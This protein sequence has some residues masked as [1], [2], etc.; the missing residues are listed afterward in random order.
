MQDLSRLKDQCGG[1]TPAAPALKHAHAPSICVPAPYLHHMQVEAPDG[2]ASSA[3]RQGAVQGNAKQGAA[4]HYGSLPGPGMA[5]Q[6]WMQAFPAV[7]EVAVRTKEPSVCSQQ[8]QDDLLRQHDE[9]LPGSCCHEQDLQCSQSHH[10]NVQERQSNLHLPHRKHRHH[11]HHRQISTD[12]NPQDNYHGINEACEG[13][14]GGL[15]PQR[16]MTALHDAGPCNMGQNELEQDKLSTLSTSHATAPAAKAEPPQLSHPPVCHQLRQP[17]CS[18]GSSWSK[19]G[20]H[21][22][23][24]EHDESNDMRDDGIRGSSGGAL[25]CQVAEAT[26]TVRRLRRQQAQQAALWMGL[27]YTHRQG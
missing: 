2:R 7:A 18:P 6:C 21:E 26:L 11:Q 9:E 27:Q 15:M 16:W 14:A 24:H 19:F 3:L 13:H 22:G 10:Q 12:Q 23:L 20:V 8:D 17:A 4:N 5:E 1:L 25:A